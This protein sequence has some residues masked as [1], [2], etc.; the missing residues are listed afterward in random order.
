[1]SIDKS[2]KSSSNSNPSI[3]IENRE[4]P[5]MIASGNVYLR[6]G[7]LFMLGL[8]GFLIWSHIELMQVMQSQA[9]AIISV[10]YTV[11]Q[12]D[13]LIKQLEITNGKDCKP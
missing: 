4:A 3:R 9:R 6:L 1:M 11:G 13:G 2:T 12:H 8:L 10:A 7:F 5:L